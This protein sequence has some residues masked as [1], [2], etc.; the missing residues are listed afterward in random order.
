MV[1]YKGAYIK[2]RTTLNKNKS[3]NDPKLH[4]NDIFE[5]FEQY[6]SSL[7]NGH[8]KYFTTRK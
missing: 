8:E 5:E 7:Y 3:A 2:E 6:K 4:Y 1:S